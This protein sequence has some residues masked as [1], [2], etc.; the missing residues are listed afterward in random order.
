MNLLAIDTAT[1]RCAV[2][3]V[4]NG[5][6]TE[7]TRSI[8][9]LHNEQLLPMLEELLER[10]A[11]RPRDLH[12]IAFAAGPGSFTGIRISAAVAQAIALAASAGVIPI[13]SS[14]LLASAA[15][16][17][18][19]SGQAPQVY[20]EQPPEI[21]QTLLRSR[22]HYAYLATF[23]ADMQ[24]LSDD[25]LLSDTDVRDTPVP[26]NGARVMAATEEECH[27]LAAQAINV[28]ITDLL[29]LAG[30]D[31]AAG[32]LLPPAA[33]QPR[34]VSGDTPWKPQF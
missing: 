11:I 25:K 3:C 19:R 28:D 30:V 16:R 22:R 27:A 26:E 13:S 6:I 15:L 20:G 14:R 9:R 4:V 33:A 34:Y 32:K 23:A 29:D 8:P 1:D 31:Y 21:V 18:F 17:T 2:A 12:A 24:V 5:F 7:N 10:A